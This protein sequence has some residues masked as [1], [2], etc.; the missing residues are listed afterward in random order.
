MPAT[1]TRDIQKRKTKSEPAPPE[2]YTALVADLFCGAG[3]TSTGAKKAIESLGQKMS[4]VAVN[5]NPVAIETHSK[6]HPDARHYVDDVE[7]ADPEKL[8]PEGYLDLLL[9]SP[10]CRFFSRARGGRPVLDQ[11]RMKPWTVFDWLTKLR[12]RAVIVENVP[13]FT[14]WGPLDENDRPIKSKKGQHFE[15]WFMTFQ[16]LGYH[17]E[18]R[19]LNAADFG[20]ATTRTR[21]FLIARNDGVP[22]RWPEPTH[23]K[24]GA[25]TMLG[26]LPKWRSAN[27]NI[28]WE[29]PGRSLL[30]DPKYQKKPLSEKTRRRIAKGF[31]RYCDPELAPLYIELLNL[32][33]LNADTP[34]PAGNGHAKPASNP[35]AVSHRP[36]LAITDPHRGAPHFILNRH[37]ENGSIR[38]HPAT[39]PC[40]TS[41]TRG[42][43][44]L[45]SASAIPANMLGITLAAF[46][47]ANRNNNVPKDHHHP[48]APVTTTPSGGG[49]YLINADAA[50]VETR[51][52]VLGQH[53]GSIARDT[54]NPIPTVA[55]KGA[56]SLTE[57]SLTIFHGQ[58][59]G[60]TLDRPLST[61]LG[62]R[63][64]AL[65]EPMLVQYYGQGGC[66]PVSRPLATIT[67]RD[68]YALAEPYLFEVNHGDSALIPDK[69]RNQPITHPLRTITTKRTTA[70]LEPALLAGRTALMD[71]AHGNHANDP[72][73]DDRRILD[74]LMPLPTVT[75]T[76]AFAIAA[77]VLSE[78]SPLP[79][80]A[81][82]GEYPLLTQVL[83]PLIVQKA[84]T[85]GN[86][87][88]VRPT[89]LPAPTI[90]TQSDLALALPFLVPNFGERR[91]Q[92]PRTHSLFQPLATVTAKGACNLV[93]PAAE[94]TPPLPEDIDP[95]RIV[96]LNGQPHVL[97]IKFRMLQN[98]ELAKA[99]GFDDDEITYEFSGTATQ[100]TKQIG[101]A[102]PVNLA[103]ALV[104]ATLAPEAP[105]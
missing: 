74:W 89:D 33:E 10:E 54:A 11:A 82:E 84:Q 36:N 78:H 55:Q 100:I 94:E 51:P 8:V 104:K 5:H 46:T 56:I 101:N 30:D 70:I 92:C 50:P 44:Y 35:N 97:D 4:L 96:Y 39:D 26:H 79:D 53:S 3:G 61:I 67:T 60:Q 66:Y 29:N 43:G 15:S 12:V 34:E 95:R 17:A 102:V 93:V 9:A 75:T 76:S 7:H 13:E 31:D 23:S 63:K 38:V 14:Q 87:A 58:S 21:F 24:H 41:T 2:Q 16:N 57:P 40:P 91:N 83:T 20:D 88:Y 47:M 90:T 69:G 71:L 80:G 22:I 19:N 64:H 81:F 65:I 37:G 32:P 27:E 62:C 99:M 85:G 77:P 73:A 28:N 59:V 49:L 18:Y 68:R 52:F 42:A 72:T 25:A 45:L 103:A 86:G 105:T 48:V 98:D 1:L 6:N